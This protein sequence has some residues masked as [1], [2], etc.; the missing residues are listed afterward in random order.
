MYIFDLLNV[1]K[2]IVHR[3][4]KLENLLLNNNM[5]KLVIADF[6]LSNF[7]DGKVHLRTHCGSP[8]YAAPE[9]FEK[10]NYSQKVERSSNTSFHLNQYRILGQICQLNRHWKCNLPI[11]PHV[12]LSVGR[13]DGWWVGRSALIS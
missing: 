6:G 1:F 10:A 9:L 3:D 8:E 4:L 11:N 5:Q 2:G 13:L 7:W 12:R